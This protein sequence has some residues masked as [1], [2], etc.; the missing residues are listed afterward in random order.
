MSKNLTQ[1]QKQ[2]MLLVIQSDIKLYEQILSDVFDGTISLSQFDYD[3]LGWDYSYDD[4]EDYFRSNRRLT[5]YLNNQIYPKYKKQIDQLLYKRQ[6]D[7]DMQSIIVSNNLSKDVQIIQK[8]DVKDQDLLKKMY[9]KYKD[10]E[11]K[12]MLKRLVDR[13]DDQIIKGRFQRSK[14]YQPTLF[15]SIAKSL[16]ND[17]NNAYMIA[18]QVYAASNYMSV[19]SKYV[20]QI[21]QKVLQ[22][23]KDDKLQYNLCLKI[24]VEKYLIK[25]QLAKDL[26]YIF[27]EIYSPKITNNQ[28]KT[29]GINCN[30]QFTPKMSH[31]NIDDGYCIWFEGQGKP[32]Q[33]QI[34]I[35]VD[36]Q[37]F[38]NSWKIF[39]QDTLQHQL[40]HIFEN[41]F[42]YKNKHLNYDRNNNQN[43]QQSF[44]YINDED[45]YADFDFRL[46]DYYADDIQ[47]TPYLADLIHLFK[48]L[49]EKGKTKEEIIKRLKK[50]DFKN[51]Y[52]VQDLC[53]WLLENVDSSDS[54]IKWLFH[55]YQKDQNLF[56]YAYKKLVGK[57]LNF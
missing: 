22:Y 52:S 37:N 43:Y 30:D 45:T 16:Y 20:R 11:D 5:K 3:K 4:V 19:C 42:G 50:T 29:I 54:A 26:N 56:K 57:I 9:Q 31:P 39:Y 38:E 18:K 49:Y 48:M 55:V 13:I 1:Q 33:S 44:L 23:V 46:Q 51:M 8:Y 32:F 40:I 14:F 24:K 35:G 21:T 2:Q 7:K 34:H 27:V 53:D 28:I 15:A 6:K 36:N 17:Y 25:N 12:N 41:H 10:N 47:F